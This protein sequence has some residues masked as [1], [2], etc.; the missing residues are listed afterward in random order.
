MTQRKTNNSQTKGHP[1]QH[2]FSDGREGTGTQDSLQAGH[3]FITVSHLP[4]LG[5]FS[6]SAS[7]H[8][9]D[10]LLCLTAFN[11][12][13]FHYFFCMQLLFEAVPVSGNVFCDLATCCLG[14]AV[15]PLF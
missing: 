7:I 6:F 1:A 2:H 9:E 4:A 12:L 13:L 3:V 15:Q 10:A 8:A 11:G 5:N 14:G